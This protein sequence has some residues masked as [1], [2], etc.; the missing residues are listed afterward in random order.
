MTT[1][2]SAASGCYEGENLELSIKYWHKFQRRRRAA[3]TSIDYFVG[4]MG[5]G[6]V[7][8]IATDETVSINTPSR[9]L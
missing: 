4:W 5:R 3:A 1:L 9:P 8:M 2:R 6:D 7:M